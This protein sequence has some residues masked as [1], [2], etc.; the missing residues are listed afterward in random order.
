MGVLNVE[1]NDELEKEFRVKVLERKGSKKGAL[2]EAV[3]EALKLWIEMGKAS[4]SEK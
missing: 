4:E 2:T 3:E 1:I